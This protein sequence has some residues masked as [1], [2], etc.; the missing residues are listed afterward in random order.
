MKIPEHLKD[1][2]LAYYWSSKTTDCYYTFISTFSTKRS[3]SAAKLESLLKNYKTTVPQY[4][5]LLEGKIL[6]SAPL[7]DFLTLY[8]EHFL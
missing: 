2:E 1:E 5:L 4:T 7:K 6:L 8:P 3:R